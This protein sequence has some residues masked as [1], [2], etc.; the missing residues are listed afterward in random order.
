MSEIYIVDTS[1]K[2][3]YAYFEVAQNLE[4]SINLKV[5][6]LGKQTIKYF[7]TKNDPDTA[8]ISTQEQHPVILD[9]PQKTKEFVA[10]YIFPKKKDYQTNTIAEGYCPSKKYLSN[11]R[12]VLVVPKDEN[13]PAELEVFDREETLPSY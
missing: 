9:S 10:K 12:A 1:K 3:I 2:D 6:L 4:T 7:E 13:D 8:I 11:K 5:R